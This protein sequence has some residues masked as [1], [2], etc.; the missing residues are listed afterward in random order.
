M[1]VLRGLEPPTSAS[2]GLRSF[3]LSYGQMKTAPPVRFERTT[4]GFEGRYSIRAEL[5]GHGVM[6]GH[7]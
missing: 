2:A 1:V 4:F 3:Q 5:R 6:K 7:G